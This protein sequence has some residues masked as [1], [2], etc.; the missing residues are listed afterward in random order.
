M[1]PGKHQILLTRVMK[2]RDISE[3]N[4]NAYVA[5]FHAVDLDSASVNDL[6][7]P[8]QVRLMIG[9]L[10]VGFIPCIYLSISQTKKNLTPLFKRQS[11][12]SSSNI[13]N[14]RDSVSLR[15]PN[16]EKR[17]ENEMHSGVF[18]TKF[19]VFG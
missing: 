7:I 11:C 2:W 1:K 16:T 10:L 3:E 4:L 8:S 17:V 14:T 6:F 9:F 12:S 19:E 15:Y 5:G 18:W 13:P